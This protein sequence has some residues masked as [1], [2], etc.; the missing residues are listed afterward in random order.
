MRDIEFLR[1]AGLPAAVPAVPS[2]R[3]DEA[4]ADD[5][6]EPGE[7][8]AVLGCFS[9]WVRACWPDRPELVALDGK[10]LRRSH[11]RSQGQPA[12]HLVSAGGETFA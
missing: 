6:D 11:D 9:D 10:T 2:R 1:A 7:P 3:A 5:H 8:G 4:V 12:L